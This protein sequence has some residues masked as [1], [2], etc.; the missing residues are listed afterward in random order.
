MT[1]IMADLPSNW[2]LA[3]GRPKQMVE[4]RVTIKEIRAA[5]V[6]GASLS[7]TGMQLGCVATDVR[8]VEQVTNVRTDM[9]LSALRRARNIYCDG[10]VFRPRR[11]EVGSWAWVATDQ[12]DDEVACQ[13]GWMERGSSTPDGVTNNLTELTAAMAALVWMCKA[14]PRWSGRLFSDSQI[15]LGRLSQGWRM[16]G[17]P[18]R[19]VERVA[20]VLETV[21]DVEFVHLKG[22]PKPA[23]LDAGFMVS[24]TSGRTYPVSRHQVK[25]DSLCTDVL[26]RWSQVSGITR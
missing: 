12:D 11:C 6:I 19:W 8:V 14:T 18:D 20:A 7:L 9:W 25:C 13:Y 21:G 26:E 16:K 17:V 15:T 10:G 2:S 23:D 22:H 5:D 4:S 1:S 3:D 24:P